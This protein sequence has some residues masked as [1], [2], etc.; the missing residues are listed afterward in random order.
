MTAQW[1]AYSAGMPHFPNPV[2]SITM[3]SYSCRSSS[4]SSFG[5]QRWTGL[6]RNASERHLAAVV[7]GARFWPLAV[8][9]TLAVDKV[10]AETVLSAPQAPDTT[11]NFDEIETFAD[12]SPGQPYGPRRSLSMRYPGYCGAG[13]V[14]A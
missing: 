5:S 3:F 9:R 7:G 10:D 6:A 2:A 13:S 4:V 8:D 1:A 14:E 11:G 12:L